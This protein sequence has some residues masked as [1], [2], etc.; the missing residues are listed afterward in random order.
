VHGSV[1]SSAVKS[2]VYLAMAAFAFVYLMIGG[3]LVHLAQMDEAPS[4][5]G[6]PRRIPLPPRGRT[7]LTETA[8]SWRPISRRL[9]FMPSRAACL[10]LTRRVEG[11]LSVLPGLDP[12]VVRRRLESRAGFVWLKRELTPAQADRIHNLGL[13]GIGFPS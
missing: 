11:L 7:C 6:S 1:S 8:K 5:P 9:R 2:R 3:R 10:M 4:P 12:V 13:P